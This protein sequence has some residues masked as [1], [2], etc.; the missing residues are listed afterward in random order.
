MTVESCEDG[1]QF[2][3]TLDQ[4]R[5]YHSMYT[6]QCADGYHLRSNITAYKCHGGKWDPPLECR[7][8]GKGNTTLFTEIYLRQL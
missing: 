3:Q 7:P 4:I 2:L 5:A 6:A 1:I 8:S